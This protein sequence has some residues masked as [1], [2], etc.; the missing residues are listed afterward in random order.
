MELIKVHGSG[1]DFFILDQEK[2]GRKISE[3]E[4]KQ[5]AIKVCDRKHGFHGGADGILCVLPETRGD[6]LGEC[7]SSM[8]TEAKQACAATV[9]ERLR[10]I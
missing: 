9:S 1:N 3:T 2:L 10:A 5:L 8:Q 6:V 7:A 4:L